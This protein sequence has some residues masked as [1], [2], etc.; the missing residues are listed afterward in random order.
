LFDFSKN[1][2]AIFLSYSSVL[3][4]KIENINYLHNLPNL[5]MIHVKFFKQKEEPAKVSNVIEEVVE[6][7]LHAYDT[8]E[9][10]P[11]IHD[12][13]DIDEDL[14]YAIQDALIKKQCKRQNIQV[15][16]YKISMT[17][18]ETQAIAG[19]NEPA[20]GTLLTTNLIKSGDTLSL[21]DLFS[22]LIETEIMFILQEDLS[23]DADVNE[24]LQKSKL[25]A[26]IEIPDARYINWFPNF[27]LADLLSDN[28][29]TGFVVISDVIKP[30]TYE[31]LANVKME[32]F[33]N[34]EKIAEGVSSAVL[35][36][37]VDA[38][39]WLAQKLAKHDKQLKKGMVISSG[40]FISPPVVKEGT[41]TVTYTNIGEAK[42]TF[43]K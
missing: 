10:I 14:G 1:I 38:V 27:K 2:L 30:L 36:N 20:Y 28:T 3:P 15:A 34:D 7:I 16:G 25:A 23:P 24:V 39:I 29:A 31:Q 6:K 5:Y 19:V 41:Y 42:I 8:K 4:Y 37:P 33:H 9:P 26:G 12:Q 32:L 22:P 43:V 35:G 18:P 11:F 13:Y 40:T 21:S 17:T